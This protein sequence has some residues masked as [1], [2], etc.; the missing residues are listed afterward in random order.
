MSILTGI[1]AAAAWLFK[2]LPSKGE[3]LRNEKRRLEKEFAELIKLPTSKK[4]T[5]RIVAIA[6]RLREIYEQGISRAT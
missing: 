1:G 3:S 5:N 6:N 4:R 2:W